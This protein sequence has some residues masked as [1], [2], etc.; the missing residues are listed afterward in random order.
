MGARPDLFKPYPKEMEPDAIEQRL[1]NCLART[2]A[3]WL[4]EI[5]GKNRE[6]ILQ[7]LSGT[8]E[9]I[10]RGFYGFRSFYWRGD[11]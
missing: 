5:R 6:P 7:L 3:D 10:D 8:M 2:F 1:R 4:M 9:W 11:E